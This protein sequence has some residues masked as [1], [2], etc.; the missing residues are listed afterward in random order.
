[1]KSI[2]IR[3][4]YSHSILLP[5]NIQYTYYYTK[6]YCHSKNIIK[7]KHRI[8]HPSSNRKIK[9]KPY[10]LETD[11]PWQKYNWYKNKYINHVHIMSSLKWI[12]TEKIPK[13]IFHWVSEV[14]KILHEQ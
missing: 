6:Y 12:V 13:V 10:T 5:H 3:I 9:T 11:T 2:E 1:M 8:T 4:E 14:K 7:K